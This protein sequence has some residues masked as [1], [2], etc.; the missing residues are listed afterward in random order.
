MLKRFRVSNF[1]SLVNV[2]FNPTGLNLLIV[3]NNAGKT[4]LCSAL[5]FL[6]LSSRSTLDEAAKAALGETWN[7]T[8]VYIKNVQTMEFEIEATL[9]NEAATLEFSYLLRL[10]SVRDPSSLGQSLIVNDE[11]L[12]V[13]REGV[14]RKNLIEFDGGE[15]KVLSNEEN[16]S[17]AEHLFSSEAT[18]LSRSNNLG[19]DSRTILFWRW[20]QSWAYYNFSPNALRSPEIVLDTR[21]LKQDG[22]NLSKVLHLLHN[23]NPRLEIKLIEELRKFEP[24]LDLFT[25]QSPD[26]SVVYLFLEDKDG[27]RFSMRSISDGT[28]RFLAMAYLILANGSISN[29]SIPPPL[30]IIEEPE[31]GLYVRALKPLIEKINPSGG[32]GQFIFTTHS[33]YMIDLFDGNLGGLHLFKPGKPSSILTRL[34]PDK[35]KKLLEEMPLGE[36]HF[37]EMLG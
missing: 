3:P 23:G 10:T 32:S 30:T 22:A 1:R 15:A 13:T 26:P 11:V 6:S 34:D 19:A 17:Y 29:P 36:L 16:I 33:P 14:Q 18:I 24:K 9:Q 27:N 28:L 5:R 25:F 37:R 35:I 2:E 8:N 21:I 4:N 31:N 7:I 20:L 12:Q